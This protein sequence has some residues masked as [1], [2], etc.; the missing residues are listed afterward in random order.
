MSIL[1]VFGPKI[2]EVSGAGSPFSAFVH[3]HVFVDVISR[4]L[5]PESTIAFD[6][7]VLEVH[8]LIAFDACVKLCLELDGSDLLVNCAITSFSWAPS[9]DLEKI[10]PDGNVLE[11]HVPFEFVFS[12]LV[13]R[14][15]TL[16]VQLVRDTNIFVFLDEFT[17]R[18]FTTNMADTWRKGAIWSL[19][20]LP[21]DGL[22]LNPV[23][24]IL[25]LVKGRQAVAHGLAQEVPWIGRLQANGSDKVVRSSAI[26]KEL[27]R[28]GWL[29][30]CRLFC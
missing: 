19:N 22:D 8:S 5:V 13:T 9:P 30:A 6:T 29:E 17:I 23:R 4:A 24:A 7:P 15:V 3:N 1:S 28:E 10:W 16:E 12:V 14:I 25:S 20:Q 2:I 11:R 27:E 26:N 21:L 18:S